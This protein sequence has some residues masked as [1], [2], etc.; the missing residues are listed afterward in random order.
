M[1]FY[2]KDKVA[3]ITG[4][5]RG[6]GKSIVESF[7]K[8]GAKK[9]YLAV[10]D[11]KSTKMLETQFGSKVVTIEM[12]VTNEES[13]LAATKITKDVDVVVNNAG[14]LVRAASLSNNVVEQLKYEMDVNVYGLLHVANAY[15][16]I[17]IENKGALV[18][19]NSIASMKNFPDLS[20]YSASKAA[21]YSITQGLREQ[22]AI[23]NVQVVSVHPGPIATDMGRSAGFDGGGRSDIVAE[24]IVEAL[25]NNQFHLFPDVLAKKI[26]NAYK[27]FSDNIIMTQLSE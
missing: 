21:S 7:I 8:H 24:N 26:G 3:L 25:I 11:I 23:H 9:V 10:R 17:L 16:D 6:I 18:Q 14:V 27:S 13:I 5:N 2:I 15:K 1:S 22:F 20:T 4:A 19:L 12:D